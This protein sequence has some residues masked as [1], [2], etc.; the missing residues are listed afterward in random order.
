[1]NIG[2]LL[3]LISAA[4]HTADFIAQ[5]QLYFYAQQF[6]D[7]LLWGFNYHALVSR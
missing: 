5:Q 6:I 7:E 1:M 2:F 4:F 3:D